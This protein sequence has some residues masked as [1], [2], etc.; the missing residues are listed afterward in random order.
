MDL[1]DIVQK[2]KADKGLRFAN[3]LIDTILFYC[4]FLILAFVI[5]FI[6]IV[7]DFDTSFLV[8]LEN[9]H[10]LLDRLITAIIMV[11]YFFGFETLTKGRS[12]G[13]F[14]TGT[15]VVTLEGETPTANVFLKRSFCR[16]IPFEAFSFFGENGWHDSIPKTAVVVK[17]HFDYESNLSLDVDTIGKEFE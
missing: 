5:G 7:L 12:I 1:S 10:P 16:I 4:S 2:N 14:I 3:F 13:K 17:K 15:K 9:I 6:A 8:E 11:F